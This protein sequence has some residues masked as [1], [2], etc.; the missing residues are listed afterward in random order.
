MITHCAGFTAPGG[1]V[2]WGCFSDYFSESSRKPDLARVPL[3]PLPPPRVAKLGRGGAN[4]FCRAGS[5]A[6][7]APTQ[8]SEWAKPGGRRCL[9]AAA[10][11]S[12]SATWPRSVRAP[13]LAQGR[14][15]DP[16]GTEA[17]CGAPR[18]TADGGAWPGVSHVA[19]SIPLALPP[20]AS[21]PK[22]FG[23]QSGS[24]GARGFE[25]SR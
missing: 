15:G 21:L 9:T 4:L 6:R 2:F 17:A 7:S 5:A 14:R 25:T 13:V 23:L 12:G 1:D 11:G 8:L 19:I 20:R 24:N 22:E 10:E 16:P 18:V 3:L